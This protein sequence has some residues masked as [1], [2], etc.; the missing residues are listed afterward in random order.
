[1]TFPLWHKACQCRKSVIYRTGTGLC[2]EYGRLFKIKRDFYI[3]SESYAAGELKHGTISLITEGMPVI[4]VATQK[5]L[6]EKTVSNIREVQSPW[7]DGYLDLRQ[8]Y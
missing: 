7:C 8:Q 6:I 4:A 1:M 3:H 5:K 2:T